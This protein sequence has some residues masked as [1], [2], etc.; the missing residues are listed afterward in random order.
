MKNLKKLKATNSVE[1]RI[2]EI[3]K[4]AFEISREL[5]ELYNELGSLG[6]TRSY[7]IDSSIDV[8]EIFSELFHELREMTSHGSV[9]LNMDLFVKYL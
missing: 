7:S 6:K 2:L 3:A 8:S 1:E 4:R 9:D 5:D